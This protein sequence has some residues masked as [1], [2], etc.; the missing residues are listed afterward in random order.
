METTVSYRIPGTHCQ[1]ILEVCDLFEQKGLKVIHGLNTFDTEIK[2]M[3]EDSVMGQF[4][5]RCKD[6]KIDFKAQIDEWIEKNKQNSV[7]VDTLPYKKNIF[8]LGEVC[9]ISKGKDKYLLTAFNDLQTFLDTGGMD[10]DSYL[11]FLDSLWVSLGKLG[12]KKEVLNI[13]AFGNKIVNVASDDFTIDQ[14]IGLIVQSYLKTKGKRFLFENL[15][16]CIHK[17]DAKN[18]DLSKWESIFPY[19]YQYSKLPLGIKELNV[20]QK[21]LY[22]GINKT[23]YSYVSKCENRC[24][25]DIKQVFI[26][27]SKDDC[28]EADIV[29]E[30]L[31]SQGYKCWMDAHD[32][33][34]GIPY[35]KEIMKGFK[36]SSAIVVVISKNT[37]ESK[38]VINE[39]DNVYKRNKIIIPFRVDDTPLSEELSFYLSATQWIN[40][41]PKFE[42]HLDDLGKALKQ[43]LDHDK[44]IRH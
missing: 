5:K 21:G 18:L 34:P 29:Y 24:N 15:K 37:M 39:V 23:N 30:Y 27:H 14:K 36:A 43:L 19:L 11:Y 44:D 33:T 3:R 17:S 41:F 20:K 40:A 9:Q 16:I 25:K 42:E 6:K 13:P 28:H 35:A 4:I 12:L 38:G 32:I 10:L 22:A 1:I 8:N 31:E 2:E 7:A 26:S